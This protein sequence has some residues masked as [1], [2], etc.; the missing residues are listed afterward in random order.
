L[1][2]EFLGSVVFLRSLFVKVIGEGILI[3]V[4]EW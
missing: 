2:N 3:A 4:P 1:A